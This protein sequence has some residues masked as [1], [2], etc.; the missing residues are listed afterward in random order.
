MQDQL[1]KALEAHQR[2]DFAT[3]DRLYTEVL[4]TEPE[5]YDALRLRGVLLLQRGAPD[6]SRVLL[7]RATEARPGDAE[8]WVNLATLEQM[9]GAL[10]AAIAA[11]EKALAAD[12][13][14]AA[15]HN[16]H[17][18]VLLMAGQLPESEAAY[19]RALTLEP[20]DPGLMLNLAG[21]LHAQGRLDDAEAG[22]R[23]A[24]VRDPN[25]APAEAKLGAILADAGD[26]AAAETVLRA[27]LQ[28][29]PGQAE[30][31]YTLAQL[32]EAQGA[33]RGA[34]VEYRAAAEARPD[35]FQPKSS[36]MFMARRIGDWSQRDQDFS[37]YRAMIDERRPGAS[38]FIALFETEDRVMQRDAARLWAAQIMQSVQ[39]I[40]DADRFPHSER[41]RDRITV[42]YLSSGFGSHATAA[43]TAGVFEQHDRSRFRTI[44][45]SLA[46]SDGTALS[47]RVRRSFDLFHEVHELRPEQI[48][49]RI[50]SDEVDVLVDLNGYTDGG[51]PAVLALHPAPVQI[52]WLAYPGTMGGLAHYLV[53]DQ[54][55]VRDGEDADYDEAV[56]RLS[57]CYQPTDPSRVIAPTPSRSD[58]GLPEDAV[59]LACFNNGY[60]ISPEVFADWMAILD[61]VPAAVLWLLD[62]SPDQALADNLRQVASAQGVDPERLY[63]CGKVAHAEYLA[64]YRVADLVLDTFPYTAHTTASD[65][66]F[67]GCPVLT[68]EGDS[69]ASRV[70]ASILADLGLDALIVS[71]ADAYRARAIEL[72]Q[73]ADERDALRAR[74]AASLDDE[75]G[76]RAGLWD[77]TRYARLWE[78]ALETAYQRWR[79]GEPIAALDIQISE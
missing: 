28:K 16:N 65:A 1:N 78:T 4:A 40:A 15:A 66:L 56:I 60:K 69:F 2:G 17:G 20:G 53:A 9:V 61:A 22:C 6:E 70:A 75:A 34:L 79:T 18:N 41:D 7:L 12:P 67:A 45:Y 47:D 46:P 27:A 35:W 76:G 25:F 72:A 19:R 11:L 23:E 58:L 24:L 50:H 44:A 3:A 49:E 31:R 64:R 63:F 51:Q 21:A 36:A 74:I 33:W 54:R 55:L 14:L 68:R 5:N 42:G 29:N 13:R 48:A 38:P 26:L 59:V 39:R 30:W 57:G 73:D 77:P 43:L 32:I 37:D 10:D 71:D 52:S 8:A 62:T